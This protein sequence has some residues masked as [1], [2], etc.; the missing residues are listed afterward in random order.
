MIFFETNLY[1]GV[2]KIKNLNYQN[3]LKTEL[4]MLEL[5]Q[6]NPATHL[7]RSQVKKHKIKGVSAFRYY[8][9]QL[10]KR[11]LKRSW[12][13]PGG[14]QFGQDLPL[15]LIQPKHTWYQESKPLKKPKKYHRPGNLIHTWN[16]VKQTLQSWLR[17]LCSTPLTLSFPTWIIYKN[18]KKG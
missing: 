17:R 10:V 8:Q 12:C 15:T 13:L 1:N 11:A 6:W 7:Q 2:D 5:N 3:D 18:E 4:K 9:L 16:E 14:A